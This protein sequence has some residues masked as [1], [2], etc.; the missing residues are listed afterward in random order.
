MTANGY[1]RGTREM[2]SRQYMYSPK[3]KA[4]IQIVTPYSIRAL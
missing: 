3:F 4:A 2:R 1:I